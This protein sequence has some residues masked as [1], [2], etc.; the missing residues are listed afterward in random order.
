LQGVDTTRANPDLPRALPAMLPATEGLQT[1]TEVAFEKQS[2]G[3][4]NS[5]WI[6]VHGEQD[7]KYGKV[8][9]TTVKLESGGVLVSVRRPSKYALI[10]T[11]DGIVSLG[12]DGD[13][14]AS[15]KDGVL[16]L[17]N[18]STRGSKCKIKLD[19][20]VLGNGQAVAL[21]PGYEMVASD[22]TLTRSD[23]RP[24]DG[25]ARRGFSLL[26]NGHVGVNEFSV[27]SFLNSSSIIASVVA[28]GK[29]PK[30]TRILNDMSKM[31]AVLNY[32]NGNYGYTGG[33][34]TGLASKPGSEAK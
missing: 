9:P 16:R 13:V 6:L 27:E 23:L 1:I 34:A 15:Y 30:E 33:A 14:L 20:K 17:H 28:G 7:S 22:R 19:S 25:I 11:P 2:S 21:A 31:A 3:D 4:E 5:D 24:S 8:S 12:A 29:D 32:V 18:L 10:Q 26:A